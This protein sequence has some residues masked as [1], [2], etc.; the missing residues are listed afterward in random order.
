MGMFD[1]FKTQNNHIP[2]EE[3][4]EKPEEFGLFKPRPPKEHPHL[5]PYEYERPF[6]DYNAA[7]ELVGYW[8]YEGDQLVLEF[9]IDG[10]VVIEDEQL[11]IP[12]ED[13]VKGKFLTLK[14][15]NFRMEEVLSR[16]YD[17]A[18]TIT[19]D[20]DKEITKIFHKGVW[21]CSLDLWDG[22]SFNRK[23]YLSE[24]CTLTVK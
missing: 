2:S 17:G 4:P 23:L 18:T 6:E 16:T 10:E 20:I 19:F 7:G 8:W 12:A 5:K 22:N 1:E 13:F 15:Y 24:Y 3:C 11:Y 9:E 21:H 14:F